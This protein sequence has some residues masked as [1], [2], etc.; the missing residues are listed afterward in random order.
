MEEK[1]KE[2]QPRRPTRRILREL[3]VGDVVKFPQEKAQSI[4]SCCSEMK[5]SYNMSFRTKRIPEERMV[6]VSRVS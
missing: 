6:Q 5:I 3:S 2:I 4:R 1:E